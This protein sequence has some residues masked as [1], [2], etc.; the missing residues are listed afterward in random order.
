M[1]ITEYKI[2][3]ARTPTENQKNVGIYGT[4]SLTIETDEG[5]LATF[6]EL[7]L[8][9]TKEGNAYIGVPYRA[10][11]KKDGNDKTTKYYYYILFPNAK[12]KDEMMKP[13]MAKA[14]QAIEAAGSAKPSSSSNTTNNK[15]APA[16]TNDADSW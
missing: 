3:H 11:E 4:F 13:I 7:T 16:A 6:K 14:R 1:K 15:P 8:R 2:E 12:N 9:K 10:G 5:P